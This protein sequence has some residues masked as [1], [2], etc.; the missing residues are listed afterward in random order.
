[1]KQAMRNYFQY[2]TMFIGEFQAW[3][4]FPRKRGSL[5]DEGSC[6]R[7]NAEY[8]ILKLNT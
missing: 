7:G 5:S 6:F 1:M 3:N 2:H 8:L 4:S